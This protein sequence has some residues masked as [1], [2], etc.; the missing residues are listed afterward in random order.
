[1]GFVHCPPNTKHT[2]VGAGAEGCVCIAV[3]AREHQDGPGWGGYTVDE[4]ARRHEASVEQ[5]TT[6]ADEAYAAIRERFGAREHS[7]SRE[8]W[9]PE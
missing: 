9:L 1:V 4:V 8:G 2:I 5:D 7:A 6:V 3:G